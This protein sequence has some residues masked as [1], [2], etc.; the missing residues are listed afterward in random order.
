MTTRSHANGWRCNPKA[1][2]Q[3]RREGGLPKMRGNGTK[4]RS[5]DIPPQY[6]RV[7]CGSIFTVH[8]RFIRDLYAQLRRIKK[9]RYCW[10]PPRWQL[11]MLE[12]ENEFT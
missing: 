11:A 8:R 7:F 4:A 10:A 2:R 6:Q 3:T 1:K 5:R 12:A 9:G